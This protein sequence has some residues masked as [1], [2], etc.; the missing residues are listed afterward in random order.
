M[1]NGNT[2]ILLNLRLNESHRPIPRQ[3]DIELYYKR[4]KALALETEN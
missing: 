3:I 2:P 1:K 4:L